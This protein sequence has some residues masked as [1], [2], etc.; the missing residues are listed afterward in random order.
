M[1]GSR[2]RG[3][4]AWLA[5]RVLAAG[6]LT[7]L[8]LRGI[9]GD[10]VSPPAARSDASTVGAAV[11][12]A[13]TPG[14]DRAALVSEHSA[15]RSS[16][17]VCAA[18]AAPFFA[19]PEDVVVVVG[20]RP[21]VRL[22]GARLFVRDR[23]LCIPLDGAATALA[24]GVDEVVEVRVPGYVPSFVR[25]DVR[26]WSVSSA[27]GGEIPLTLLRWGGCA[28][29]SCRQMRMANCCRSKRC[30]HHRCCRHPE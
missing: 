20:G 16:L 6:L 21:A 14:V 4:R 28:R 15:A 23:R 1:G 30:R 25:G 3:S 5:V 7:W 18:P 8:V 9:G 11:I 12:D 2:S 27:P 17:L 26:R 19:V 10:R 13:G 22:D 24:P 29:S